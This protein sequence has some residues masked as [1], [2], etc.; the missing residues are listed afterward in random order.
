MRSKILCN[1]VTESDVVS[2]VP[3]GCDHGQV[4][5]V[6][7][8]TEEDEVSSPVEVPQGVGGRAGGYVIQSQKDQQG[9][10]GEP[11]KIDDRD[12]CRPA[13]NFDLI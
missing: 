11:R 9:G 6:G 1:E 10:K 2:V 8:A 13:P 4:D 12:A 5:E 3:L 7:P